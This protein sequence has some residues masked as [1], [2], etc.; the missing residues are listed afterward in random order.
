MATRKFTVSASDGTK[1]TFEALD[2]GRVKLTT[3][4]VGAEVHTNAEGMIK[5]LN[6]LLGGEV[7]REARGDHEEGHHHSHGEVHHDH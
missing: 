2:D 5:M 4:E 3:G 6:G 7:K 1:F